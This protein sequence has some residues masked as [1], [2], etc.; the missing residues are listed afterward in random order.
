M[1]LPFSQVRDVPLATSTPHQFTP[2]ITTAPIAVRQILLSAFLVHILLPLLPRLISLV[3]STQVVGIEHHGPS[4]T[5][6]PR[7]LQM[8]LVLSTQARYTSFFPTRDFLDGEEREERD[9]ETRDRVEDLGRAVRWSLAVAAGEVEIEEEEQLPDTSVGTASTI[10]V[11]PGLQRGPSVSQAGRLR[12]RMRNGS[13]SQLEPEIRV[14]SHG[15]LPP[16]QRWGRPRIDEDDGDDNDAYAGNDLATPQITGTASTARFPGFPA[17]TAQ[18]TVR[19]AESL[20]TITG[21]TRRH[22]RHERAMSS[23]ESDLT[24]ASSGIF[25]RRKR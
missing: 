11:R 24:T 19:A 25:A 1:F 6:L 9:E 20:A 8:S 3:S 14:V 23:G 22:A 21:D 12:R 4:A 5:D 17:S 15:T 16:E 18:S 7:L 10:P 2:I 13:V